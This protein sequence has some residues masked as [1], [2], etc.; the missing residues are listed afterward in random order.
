M[1]LIASQLGAT[2]RELHHPMT[3]L[4]RAERVRSVGRKQ[5]M[6]YF[7]AVNGSAEASAA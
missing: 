7:P 1:V 2:V 3:V 6:R 4:K 5:H